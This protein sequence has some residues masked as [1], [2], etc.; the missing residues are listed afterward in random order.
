M[1]AAFADEDDLTGIAV[2]N[3]GDAFGA[4]G[5]GRFVLLWTCLPH[6]ELGNPH[7]SPGTDGY[8]G[9]FKQIPIKWLIDGVL[10]RRQPAVLGA[11]IEHLFCSVAIRRRQSSAGKGCEG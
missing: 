9:M 6:L 2:E 5:C 3:V 4:I 1:I 10:Q 11:L 8:V 7:G